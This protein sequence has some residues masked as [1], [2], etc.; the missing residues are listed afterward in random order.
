MDFNFLTGMRQAKMALPPWLAHLGTDA[1]VEVN[2]LRVLQ[3]F[4]APEDD[5]MDLKSLAAS[6]IGTASFLSCKHKAAFM[7]DAWD[8]GTLHE[9]VDSD[10]QQ[11]CQQLEACTGSRAFALSLL[12]SVPVGLTLVKCHWR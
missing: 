7:I 3:A 4:V 12:P 8:S 9:V 1:R 11:R 6:L 2:C 10:G 5:T